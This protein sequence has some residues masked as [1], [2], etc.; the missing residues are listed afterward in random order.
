[1]T[2][3]IHLKFMEISTGQSLINVTIKIVSCTGPDM[4]DII[5]TSSINPSQVDNKTIYIYNH[6]TIS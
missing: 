5:L 1:M 4:C 3:Q 6:V 2:I